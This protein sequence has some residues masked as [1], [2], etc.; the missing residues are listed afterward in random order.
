MAR[1]QWGLGPPVPDREEPADD[2]PNPYLPP[3]AQRELRRARDAERR[4]RRRLAARR[5][6]AERAG[7]RR[8]H[9]WGAWFGALLGRR[10]AER[11]PDAGPDSAPDTEPGA[12]PQDAPTDDEPTPHGV[13]AVDVPPATDAGSRPDDEPARPRTPSRRPAPGRSAGRAAAGRSRR[14][15][16]SWLRRTRLVVAA[17]ALLTLLVIGGVL[18]YVQANRPVQ[19]DTALDVVWRTDLKDLA[20]S[21]G[22]LAGLGDLDAVLV[23]GDLVVLRLGETTYPDTTRVIAAL[24]LADGTPAW[25]LDLAGGVCADEAISWEGAPAVVCAGVHDGEQQL[26]VVDVADGS[27][28]AQAPLPWDPVSIGAGTDGVALVGPTDP[29]TAATPLAWWALDDG[30]LA[31]EPAWETDLLDVEPELEEDL[32]NS[33]GVADLR[34]ADWLRAGD[35]VLLDLPYYASMR[36]DADGVSLLDRCWSV[37]VDGDAFVCSGSTETVRYGPDGAVEWT[38]PDAALSAEAGWAVPVLVTRHDAVGDDTYAMVGLDDG[39]TL[40]EVDLDSDVSPALAGTPGDPLVVVGDRLLALAPDGARR[41]SAPL[42]DQWVS[43]VSVAG[44]RVAVVQWDLTAVFDL[45]TGERVARLDLYDAIP[46]GDR[47]VLERGAHS[48]SL[49]RLP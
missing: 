3:D 48:V 8:S 1:R 34:Q 41:W 19:P 20:A 9:S 21:P 26:L 11:D 39:A 37:L 4:S 45:A 35:A 2:E 12:V 40:G 13:R 36:V 28:R 46:V 25:R 6:A 22:P 17:A 16:R 7:G 23:S 18:T 42:G 24:A 10:K 47:L 15:P 32:R 38:V 29:A 14:G 31:V 27:V 43:R 30:G 5:A 33:D 44:D 49:V